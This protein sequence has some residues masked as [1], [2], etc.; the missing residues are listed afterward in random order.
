MNDDERQY[1]VPSKTE[2]IKNRHFGMP[3]SSMTRH[4][5][6]AFSAMIKIAYEEKLKYGEEKNKFT[7]PTNKFFELL[8]IDNKVRKHSH[9]FTKY[10]IEDDTKVESDGYSLQHTLEGLRSQV[11]DMKYKDAKGDLYEIEGTV[12]LAYFKLNRKEITFSFST[13]IDERVLTVGNAYIMQMPIIASFRSTYT[14]ALY[15]QIE[16]RKDFYRWEVSVKSFRQIMGIPEDKYSVL[17]NLKKFVLNKAIKEINSKTNYHISFDQYKKGRR[18]EKFIFS[19]QSKNKKETVF[20]EF[21]QF[22]RKHFVNKDLLDY[23]VGQNPKKHLIRVGENGLLYNARNPDY[24]YSTADA[25]RIWK[26]LYENQ[27]MIIA[28]QDTDSPEDTEEKDYSIYYGKDFLFANEMYEH[29]V[30]I[31]Q[32]SQKLKVSFYDGSVMILSEDELTKGIIH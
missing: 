26:F 6:V 25:V 28:K 18:V 3:L 10:H 12:L 17:S 5:R 11:L 22:I 31:F 9:L 21:K 14:V 15:E 24:V 16:Q 2:V 32:V 1:L 7:F 30:S 20:D 4:Q 23:R 8:G 13:W 27:E 29:I 19:W